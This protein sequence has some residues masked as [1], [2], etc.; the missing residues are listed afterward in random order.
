MSAWKKLSFTQQKE[1]VREMTGAKKQETRDRRI[2]TLLS[3]LRAG[4]RKS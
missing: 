2:A 4:R 3:N 1:Y